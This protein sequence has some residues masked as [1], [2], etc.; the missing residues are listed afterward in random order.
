M[1]AFS[2][3]DPGLGDGRIR[4]R[5]PVATD[6][7]AVYEACQDPEIQ[8]WVPIPVPYLRQ[9]ARGWIA[10]A[11]RGWS[12]GRHGA[13]AIADAADDRLLG[14]IG[15]G[16]IDEHRATIGYWVM[17]AERRRG[18]ATSA[19]RLLARWALTTLGLRRLDLY[20]FFGNDASARVVEKVG[21]QREGVLR[22][23]VVVRGV[24]RDCVMYSLLASDVGTAD[25]R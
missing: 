9:H 11:E 12:E 18:V 24:G 21:F 23:Y 13:L 22:E 25:R 8:R 17:L 7:A 10:E 2:V 4:L 1:R 15:V 16:P 20:H 6:E 19:V 5:L 14:A 3:P